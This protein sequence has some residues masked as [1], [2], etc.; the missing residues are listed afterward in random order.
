MWREHVVSRVD[1]DMKQQTWDHVKAAAA[2]TDGSDGCLT[3]DPSG[4]PVISS[5]N[6]D[7]SPRRRITAAVSLGRNI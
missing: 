3:S 1:S 4:F 6:S 2:Q 5:S 7:W